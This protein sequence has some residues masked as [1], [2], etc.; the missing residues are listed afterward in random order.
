M[1]KRSILNTNILAFHFYEMD[2]CTQRTQLTEMKAMDGV[3]PS[4]LE[5]KIP[6]NNNKTERAHYRGKNCLTISCF[7]L[8]FGAVELP[9]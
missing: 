6:Q 2:T 3:D 9:L 8:T 5:K 7:I 1:P 4:L